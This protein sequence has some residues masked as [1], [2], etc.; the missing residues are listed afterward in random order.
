MKVIS[1]LAVSVFSICSYANY[2]FRETCIN[3]ESDIMFQIVFDI[4]LNN[5]IKSKHLFKVDCNKKLNSDC[6]IIK[7]NLEAMDIG[8]M[9]VVSLPGGKMTKVEN[10]IYEVTIDLS[11]KIHYN[12]NEKKVTYI[13]N[14]E[15]I[16]AVTEV[17]CK[18]N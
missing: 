11:R 16:N 7:I 12:T 17:L 2:E 5:G 6:T 18:G 4:K 3:A 14:F 8:W 13:Y 15:K 9:D 10:G 1:F